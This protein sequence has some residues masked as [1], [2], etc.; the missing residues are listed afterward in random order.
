[1]SSRGMSKKNKIARGLKNVSRQRVKK[2]ISREGK[3]KKKLVSNEKIGKS[4]SRNFLR[5]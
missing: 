4:T 1:M 3:Q 5:I 2:E